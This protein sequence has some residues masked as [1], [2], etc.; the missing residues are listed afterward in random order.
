M[1]IFLTPEKNNSLLKLYHTSSKTLLPFTLFSVYF[2][3][4]KNKYVTPLIHTI[5]LANVSYHSYIS[6]SC[7]I[8]DYLKPNIIAKP[9]RV[10]NIGLHAFA[11][12]GYLYNLLSKKF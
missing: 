8:T 6:C 2:Y 1:N 12:I 5:T 3:N 10:T 11:S 7:I 4:N 9:A